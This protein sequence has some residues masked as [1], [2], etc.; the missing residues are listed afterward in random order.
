MFKMSMV[1]FAIAFMAFA[2]FAVPI[3]QQ[4]QD[5]FM[6]CGTQ[7]CS[8]VGGTMNSGQCEYNDPGGKQAQ[9][10]TCLN[11]VCSPA[12]FQCTAPNSG[13]AQQYNNC[14]AGCSTQSC[15]EEC[16]NSGAVCLR[17]SGSSTT[18]GSTPGSSSTG[19]GCCGSALIML[20]ALGF[21][22]FRS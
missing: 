4:C 14:K 21:V 22:A 10:D 15:I 13:C 5:A 7:C 1:I 8:G 3:P 2:A 6:S 19:G 20:A 18:G 17:D 16:F 9:L 12:L 11:N